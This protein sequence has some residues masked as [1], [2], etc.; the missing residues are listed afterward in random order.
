MGKKCFFQALYQ[1]SGVRLLITILETNWINGAAFGE[2][3][4][5]R[6]PSRLA[7]VREISKEDPLN[8]SDAQKNNS[9]KSIFY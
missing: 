5:N 8:S 9:N 1:T 6:K 2:K 7:S 4:V 3:P